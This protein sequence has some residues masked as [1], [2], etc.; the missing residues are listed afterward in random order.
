LQ[1][2][3]RPTRGFFAG[4]LQSSTL[5]TP[6]L[7]GR[8][9][10]PFCELCSISSNNPGN[11]AHSH[12]CAQKHKDEVKMLRGRDPTLTLPPML[13][14]MISPS[15]MMGPKRDVFQKLSPPPPGP[16]PCL[17]P[18]NILPPPHGAPSSI[19]TTPLASAKPVHHQMGSGMGDDI[20]TLFPRRKAGQNRPG[21]GRGPVVLTLEQLE[22]FYG[23]P[24][25]VAAKRLVGAQ[26]A[27]PPFPQTNA[28][29][30]WAVLAFSLDGWRGRLRSLING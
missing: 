9:L 16:F 1:R 28:A 3:R 27:S 26:H 18:L 7:P 5:P 10:N 30:F 29:A 15:M 24:L 2:S 23:M 17:A 8:I 22:Q 19:P 21:G 4:F 25:H 20:V 13:A 12:W 11:G 14:P 6:F